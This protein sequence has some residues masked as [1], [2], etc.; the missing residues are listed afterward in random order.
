[1]RVELHAPTMA[2][3]L[4]SLVLALLAALGNVIAIPILTPIAPWLAL[5]AYVALGLSTMLRTG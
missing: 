5:V 2:A 3:V 1:M 4:V